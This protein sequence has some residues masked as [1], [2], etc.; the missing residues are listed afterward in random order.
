MKKEDIKREERRDP[1]NQA[2]RKLI[3]EI[4]LLRDHNIK[5]EIE[6][7]EMKENISALYKKIFVSNGEIS[8]VEKIRCN[9]NVLNELKEEVKKHN[10]FIE[11]YE[12]EIKKFWETKFFSILTFLFG[13]IGSYIVTHLIK[14]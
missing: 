2:I 13:I 14:G 11:N 3:D 5:L 8:I 10:N 12:K 6:V 1:K 7:K 9:E 4:R